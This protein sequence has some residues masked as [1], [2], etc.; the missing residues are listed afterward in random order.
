MLRSF[1]WFVGIVV[2]LVGFAVV[3]FSTVVLAVA[4]MGRQQ[5][6]KNA[7][8]LIYIYIYIQPPVTS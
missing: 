5:N 1:L 6:V 4:S 2:Q 3:G 8:G 7:H